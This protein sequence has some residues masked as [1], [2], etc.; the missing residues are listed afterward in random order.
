[1]WWHPSIRSA[2][3]PH[4]AVCIRT[5][6]K[7]RGRGEITGYTGTNDSAQVSTIL[8]KYTCVYSSN[9]NIS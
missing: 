7:S 5:A 3:N 8:T 1:M 6:A 4:N 9:V 2:L